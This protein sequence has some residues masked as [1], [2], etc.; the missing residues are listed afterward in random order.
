[1]ERPGFPAT[2][3]VHQASVEASEVFFAGRA[4]GVPVISDSEG[5]LFD[6]FG[7]GRGRL[8]QLLGPRVWWRGLR[9]VLKGHFVGLPA[10]DP[11]RMPGAFLLHG[12]DVAWEFRARH[13]GDLPNLAE[14]PQGSTGPVEVA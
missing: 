10:G 9:S 8:G 5:Q 13:A 2:V 7:L 12:R 6:G 1:M 14:I 11:L 4:P 3:F